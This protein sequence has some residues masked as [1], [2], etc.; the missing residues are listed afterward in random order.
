MSWKNPFGVPKPSAIQTSPAS[1]ITDGQQQKQRDQLDKTEKSCRRL[2][3]ELKKWR[4][5]Q[6][7]VAKSE[8]VMSRNVEL[9]ATCDSLKGTASIWSQSAKEAGRN[10]DILVEDSTATCCEGVKTYSEAMHYAHW[11]Q[12]LKRLDNVRQECNRLAARLDKL[13]HS[14]N[15]DNAQI[16]QVRQ[17]LL[18]NRSEGEA[19]EKQS[20]EEMRRFANAGRSILEPSFEAFLDVQ[21]IPR[22]FLLSKFLLQS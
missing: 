16:E 21:V 20:Q 6:M 4:D 18:N 14:A 22:A 11:Q 17:A 12:T 15:V 5:S 9:A 1:A 3:Q 7:A 19:L 8:A 10:A 2:T 13:K